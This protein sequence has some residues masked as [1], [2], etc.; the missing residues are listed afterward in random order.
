MDDSTWQLAQL[1]ISLV[2]LWLILREILF[3]QL[4]REVV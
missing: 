2:N 1:V 3:G 4:G